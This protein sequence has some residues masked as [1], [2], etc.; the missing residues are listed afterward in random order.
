MFR[1]SETEQAA[2][3]GTWTVFNIAPSAAHR[4][5]V[6]YRV[7]GEGPTL[8]ETAGGRFAKDR[9]CGFRPVRLSTCSGGRFRVVK[10]SACRD[11]RPKEGDGAMF[12]SAFASILAAG[13]TL[14]TGRKT[15]VIGALFS[16]VLS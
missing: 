14:L 11:R 9:P 8:V 7:V 4:I 5:R 12:D 1:G 2:R 16:S 13:T 10:R 15:E 6:M 3:L